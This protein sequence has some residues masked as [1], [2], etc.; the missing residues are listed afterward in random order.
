MHPTAFQRKRLVSS[1]VLSTYRFLLAHIKSAMYDI[2]PNPRMN[3][4]IYM[5][6]AVKIYERKIKSQ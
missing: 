2:S 5:T 1:K 6:L 3:G 4:A